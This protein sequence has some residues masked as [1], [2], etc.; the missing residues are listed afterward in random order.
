MCVSVLHYK[1]ERKKN[2]PFFSF[3]SFDCFKVTKHGHLV[4]LSFKTD[5]GKK[6]KGSKKKTKASA[7]IECRPELS[8]LV[9]LLGD[10]RHNKTNNP[11]PAPFML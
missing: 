9:G 10:C 5:S 8:H 11:H 4:N 3:F 6:R 1:K 2:A 7:N